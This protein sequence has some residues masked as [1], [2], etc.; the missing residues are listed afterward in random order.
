MRS[1]Q[2]M[3]NVK[4]DF[5]KRYYGHT[6][7][8]RNRDDKHSTT[9]SSH[10]WNIKDRHEN[11]NLKWEIIDRGKEFNPTT[12]KCLLCLEENSLLTH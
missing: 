7:S 8:F 4:K 11:Y 6:S 9:L 1:S 5:K 2:W 3:E 12:R 10:I